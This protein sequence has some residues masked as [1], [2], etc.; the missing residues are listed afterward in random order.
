MVHRAALSEVFLTNS[1]KIDD[2]HFQCAAQLPRTNL[3]FNDIA[4]PEPYYDLVLL[5]EIFRQAS[6]YISHAYLDVAVTDKFLYLDSK[7]HIVESGLLAASTRPTNA[8]ID[9]RVYGDYIRRGLRQGVTLDMALLIDGQPAAIHDKMSIRWMSS[10]AW[11]RIRDKGLSRLPHGV[12]SRCAPVTPT[13]PERVARHHL[14]NVVVGSLMSDATSGSF[15]EL[16]IPFRNGGIFDHPLDHI[17]GM[18]LLEGFRQS[19]LQA[20]DLALDI[21]PDRLLLTGCALVFRQ[22]GEFGFTSRCVIDDQ[23][24]S[25]SDDGR[26]ILCSRMVFQQEGDV[27]AEA[28]LTFALCPEAFAANGVAVPRSIESVEP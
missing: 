24:L 12:H 16:V 22:F 9:V 20:I 2:A 10:D 11:N 15:T 8:V 28:C 27:I 18:L 7:T 14:G 6:I 3:Y 26:S 17:P 4:S 25:L 23:A 19:A 21:A 13:A 5:V 1:I